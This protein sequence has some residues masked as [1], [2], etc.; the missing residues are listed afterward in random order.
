MITP[1]LL[2]ANLFATG[3]MAGLIWF[4]Q[5]VHYPLFAR[6]PADIMPA[7]AAEH[8]RRTTWVVMPAMLVE[9]IASVGL[10]VVPETRGPWSLAGLGLVGVVWASTFWVQV[11]LHRMM[12]RESGPAT[13][14]RL[15]VGN[16][17]RTIAWSA[18]F[19][20]AVVLVVEFVPGG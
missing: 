11:P 1:M 9:L 6:I 15:V 16:W 17:V 8:Q 19:M 20:I 3:V 13:V 7:Y 4:V 5:V 2:L 12:L 14:G 18:R 10:V